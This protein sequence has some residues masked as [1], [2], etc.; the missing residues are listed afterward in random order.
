MDQFI[1]N[2]LINRWPAYSTF[3]LPTVYKMIRIH[4]QILSDHNDTI[5]TKQQLDDQE[6]VK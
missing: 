6:S 5:R 2:Q 3:V 4:W 1:N